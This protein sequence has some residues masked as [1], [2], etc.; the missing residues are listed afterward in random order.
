MI[1]QCAIIFGCLFA[2]ELLVYFTGIKV[3][4]SIIGMLLLTALLHFKIIK[5]H[6]VKAI[7]D[8]FVSNL[9]F[10]FIP[11][12]VAIMLYF[13]V[14]KSEIVAILLTSII[15]TFIVLAVTGWVFQKTKKND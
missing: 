13:D 6:Q 8:L 15:T 9:T 10:F 1:K 7:S 11:A 4:A 2:G 14:L 3:P 12:G 5:L